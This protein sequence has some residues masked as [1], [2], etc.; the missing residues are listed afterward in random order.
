MAGSGERVPSITA[1]LEITAKTVRTWLKRFNA[2]GLAGLTDQPRSGRPMTYR[3]EQASDVI[4]ALPGQRRRDARLR[5]FPLQ[6]PN[7]GITRAPSQRTWEA[8]FGGVG[9]V[10]L[11]DCGIYVTCQLRLR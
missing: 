11:L 10:V 3:L 2:E 8:R 7:D 1:R 9:C 6:E 5:K 4:A